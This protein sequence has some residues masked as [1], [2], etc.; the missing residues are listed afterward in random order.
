M[1]SLEALSYDY[2]IANNG[3]TVTRSNEGTI[4]A[5][6]RKWG[7]FYG[8]KVDIPLKWHQQNSSQSIEIINIYHLNNMR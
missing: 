7:A 1:W 5:D 4:D 3:V 8:E 6:Q 2:D